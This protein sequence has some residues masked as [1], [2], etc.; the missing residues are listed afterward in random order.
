MTVLTSVFKYAFY[1]YLLSTYKSLPG[2]YYIRF[3]YYVVKNIITPM[4]TGKNTKN[5]KTLASDKYGV[6]RHNVISTYCSPFEVDGYFHKSNS[7]YFEE[8]DIARTDLMTKIFQ[9]LFLNSKRWPYLPVAEASTCF[10]KDIAPFQPYRIT[11]NIF[12]WDRK[13]IYVLSNFT[14][15]KG[16]TVVSLSITRYVLKD[17]RKTISPEDAL[18]TCGMYNDEVVEISERNLKYMEEN[19]GF[20]NIRKLLE[21]NSVYKKL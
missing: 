21:L 16:S 19:L 12:C 7:T 1:G 5:I 10:F 2:A 17:G 20:E 15:D 18:K 11:S 8:L 14:V 4:F 13:W 9:K 6:F 3:W